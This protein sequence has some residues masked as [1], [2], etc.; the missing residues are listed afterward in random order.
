[1]LTTFLATSGTIITLVTLYAT[2]HHVS[3]TIHSTGSTPTTTTVTTT[4]QSTSSGTQTH[5][6]TPSATILPTPSQASISSQVQNDLDAANQKA[7]KQ[8]QEQK[9]QAIQQVNEQMNDAKASI[10]RM[11]EDFKAAGMGNAADAS[12][13]ATNA[14]LEQQRQDMVKS[15]DESMTWPQAE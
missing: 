3:Q 1:M 12:L 14:Q 9:Q 11:R 7:A 5:G 15:F 8:V 6:S 10:S 4:V 13:D 2:N